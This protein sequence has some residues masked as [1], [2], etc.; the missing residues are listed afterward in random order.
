MIV[1][2]DSQEC[3]YNDNG[4]CEADQIEMVDCECNTYVHWK[5][6]CEWD[7]YDWDE[8]N[9]LKTEGESE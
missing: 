2:C 6:D 7:E 9:W 1:H 8:Y 3:R 5:E 4:T